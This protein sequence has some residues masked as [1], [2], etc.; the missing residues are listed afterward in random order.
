MTDG[1]RVFVAGQGGTEQAGEIDDAMMEALDLL[2]ADGMSLGNA[3][4]MVAACHLS[5][6]DAVEFARHAVSLRKVARG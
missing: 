6:R 1:P 2:T 5:G 4:S 3:A